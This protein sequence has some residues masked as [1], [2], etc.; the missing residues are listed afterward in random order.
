MVGGVFIALGS[1]LG[2]R[3]AH[4]DAA[5]RE[6]NLVPSTHVLRCSSYYETRPV[7]GPPNQRDYLNAVAELSTSLDAHALLGRMLEIESTRGRIRAERNGPRTL[8]LDLLLF[9]DQTCD[10]PHLTIPHPRM[11]SREFVLQPLTEL[12]GA[13]SLARLL[14]Q[15]REHAAMSAS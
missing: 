11:W 8:D 13:D 7:G 1:N 3:A 14:A 6:L 2:D 15:A 4:L 10:E 9:R 12:I 5:L